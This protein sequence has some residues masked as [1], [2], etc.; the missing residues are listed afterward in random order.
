MQPE[1]QR[2]LGLALPSSTG[3][4]S[5]QILLDLGPR[6][7]L[8]PQLLSFSLFMY[9]LIHAIYLHPKLLLSLLWCCPSEPTWKIPH[10][11]EG[12]ET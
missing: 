10:G 2:G 4:Q 6:Q 5:L 3:C 1:Q 11:P 7:S 12:F 9:P 8:P